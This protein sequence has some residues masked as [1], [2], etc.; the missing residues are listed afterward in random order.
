MSGGPAPLAGRP[1]LLQQV[2]AQGNVT[3]LS[4]LLNEEGLDINYS[5]KDGHSA[6]YSAA[7]NGPTGKDGDPVTSLYYPLAKG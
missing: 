5:C 7:K 2:A 6:L 4:T 3:L 1:A